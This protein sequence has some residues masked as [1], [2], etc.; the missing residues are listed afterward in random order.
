[1]GLHET[2]GPKNRQKTPCVTDGLKVTVRNIYSP[3]D[4][5]LKRSLWEQIRQIRITNL[6]GLW[7]VVGDFNTIRRPSE[8][9]DAY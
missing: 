4:L 3:C 7:R 5:A 9:L 8:R 6:G 1:M 2:T